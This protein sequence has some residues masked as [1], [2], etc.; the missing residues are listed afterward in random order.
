[1]TPLRQQMDQAMVLRG[2]SR[3]T[4]EAYLA[5]VAALAKHYRCSP[6]ALEARALQGY[7]LHLIEERKLA[8][9][10]VNQSVCAFRFLF[11]TVLGRAALA[12]EIPMAKVPKRLP[13]VLTRAQVAKLID[14]A[15]SLRART[16]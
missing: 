5:C 8:Y 15:T 9:A 2:F 16:L 13:V 1:M 12:P 10:S 3:R 11:G 7:L 14:S 6:D 4:R